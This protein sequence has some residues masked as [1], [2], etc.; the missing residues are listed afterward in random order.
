MSDR[1]TA[2]FR[3]PIWVLIGFMRLVGCSNRQ[4]R[5]TTGLAARARVMFLTYPSFR[6]AGVMKDR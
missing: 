1:P 4:G 2:S 5:L 6:P 3:L